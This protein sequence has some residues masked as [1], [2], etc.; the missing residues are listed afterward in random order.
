MLECLFVLYDDPYCFCFYQIRAE[1]MAFHQSAVMAINL[2]S[3]FISFHFF[4]SIVFNLAW[5]KIS[6]LFK[7]I[8]GLRRQSK[9]L[10]SLKAR[11]FFILTF[12]PHYRSNGLTIFNEILRKY[13]FVAYNAHYCFWFLSVLSV[14]HSK[15][16]WLGLWIWVFRSWFGFRLKIH[17]IFLLVL[18]NMCANFQS[19]W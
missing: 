8:R 9:I 3:Q 11:V 5:H 7:R 18:L 10:K 4:H 2:G 19:F 14:W 16:P 6:E 12:L 13:A 15:N 1:R 17:R